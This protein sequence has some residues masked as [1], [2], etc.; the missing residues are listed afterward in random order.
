MTD[1]S[2]EYDGLHDRFLLNHRKHL[3]ATWA[4]LIAT[5]LLCAAAMIVAVYVITDRID[6]NWG[7]AI[8]S[9]IAL[10]L[11][12]GFTAATFVFVTTH[13]YPTTYISADDYDPDNDTETDAELPPPPDYS[14]DQ[15][16][17]EV[18]SR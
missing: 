9:V 14:P 3:T 18:R 2:P 4:L 11:L 13:A 5:V 16:T 12:A 8:V 15:A 6:N 17:T 10:V 1:S 7:E